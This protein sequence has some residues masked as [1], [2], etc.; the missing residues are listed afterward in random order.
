MNLVFTSRNS[1]FCVVFSGIFCSEGDSIVFYDEIT[2]LSADLISQEI[3]P[4][5][6]IIDGVYFI[7]F[8]DF[9]FRILKDF[10]REI[11]ALF[12]DS[13]VPKNSRT[14]KWLS[15]IEFCFENPSYQHLIP[16]LEKINK[17]LELPVCKKTLKKIKNKKRRLIIPIKTKFIL[18]PINHL[19]YEYFFKNR[20]RIV[21]LDEI[22]E[23]LKI[24][25]TKKKNSKNDVYSYV[26]RFRKSI[27]SANCCYELLRICKGGYQLVLK[28]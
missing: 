7:R 8:K 17:I 18:S 12:L 27:A 16:V 9:I 26:S 20:K 3:S 21:Y 1:Q 25:R 4:D 22:A 11:P 28:R 2:E 5:L 14:A 19:L 13:D 6:I 15:E 10:D 23:I 24:H